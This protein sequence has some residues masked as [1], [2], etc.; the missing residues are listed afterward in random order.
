MLFL[1]D[2]GGSFLLAMIIPWLDRMTD[3]IQDFMNTAVYTTIPKRSE[4]Q[5]KFNIFTS[6]DGGSAQKQAR[7]HTR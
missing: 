6:Q 1:L 4:V 5:L 7:P 2:E 3:H